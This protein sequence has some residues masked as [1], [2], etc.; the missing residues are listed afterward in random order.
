MNGSM[1]IPNPHNLGPAGFSQMG[2][3][4]LPQSLLMSQQTNFGP[5]FGGLGELGAGIDPVLASRLQQDYTEQLSALLRG[6][7]EQKPPAATDKRFFSEDWQSSQLHA[8]T[9]AAY[10]LNARF[11]LALADAV[12]APPKKKQKI[13]FAVQQMIE[14]M[15]PAN[16]LA[17]NPEAQKKIIETEGKSLTKGLLHMLGDMRKGRISQAD[18]GAFSVGGNVAISEGMVVFENDVF[19]LIQYKPLT[20]KVFERPL[21][22]VPPCINKYYILDLQPGNSLVRYAVEQGNTVFLVS[23]CNPDASMGHLTWDNYVEDGVIKAIHAAQ[24]ISG[25]AQINV[26]GFCVGGTILSSALA[27]LFARG[28]KPVESVT[29]LTT[30]LDFSDPG[31][32]EVYIDEEQIAEHERKIGKGGVMPA[33]DFAA[34]FSSLWPSDLIWSYVAS[35]YLKGQDPPPFDLMYWNSDGSN[36]PGPMFCWYLRNMYLE[37]SLKVPGKLSMGGEKIDLGKIDAPTFI[38]ASLEDHIVRWTSAYQATTLLNPKSRKRNRFLLGASG[39]VSGVINPP[40]KNKRSYW[41]NPALGHDAA[42][43][44]VSATE[45]PGSWWPEWKDFLASHGG[46]EIDAPRKFGN[47]IYKP[48]EAAP[49][50]YVRV[51]ADS[52]KA[53]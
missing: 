27:V 4:S 23:W 28:E 15:S 31:V 3:Q 34:A 25:Q 17:S 21:L 47:R 12:Q 32:I 45:H 9:A 10:L 41:T 14:A 1:N 7:Y 20:E 50:R 39:H 6:F 5:G 16:F 43:W 53:E 29:L 13:R 37:D 24:Q 40:A 11:L 35:N 42:A 52:A 30:L 46:K 8:F 26:L 49:G 19:Q 36:L 38:Y 22:M 18:E 48:I 2:N 44:F 51:K 33:R